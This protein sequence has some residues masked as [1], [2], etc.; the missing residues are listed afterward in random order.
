ML[1]IAVAVAAVVYG[2]EAAQGRLALEIQG[3]AGTDVARTIQE[4]I[5][6]ADQP[7]TGRR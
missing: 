5:K 2:Q 3:L 1:V 4:V 6:G 7:R